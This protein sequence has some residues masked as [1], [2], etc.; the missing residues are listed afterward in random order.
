MPMGGM[1]KEWMIGEE[2]QVN[3]TMVG[4]GALRIQGM[5]SSED[6]AW[7]AGH[8][9]E[10]DW[11]TDYVV[12]LEGKEEGVQSPSVCAQVDI[13]PC[14]IGLFDAIAS[15][16]YMSGVQRAMCS[17]AQGLW[18]VREIQPVWIKR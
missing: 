17:E 3:R 12:G 10:P 5:K 16:Y 2:V 7:V 6:L 13:D 15:G 1:Q 9:A 11:V 8:V 4:S 18:K 14:K